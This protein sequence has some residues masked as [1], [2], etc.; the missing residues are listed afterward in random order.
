MYRI[1]IALFLLTPLSV[2][3]Q[4]FINKNKTQALKML[5][6]YSTGAGFE[7]PVI[8]QTDSTIHCSVKDTSGAT[9]NFIFRFD[10]KNKC[11]SEE[12]EASCDS[13]YRKYLIETLNKKIYGWTKINE[14]QYVSKYSHQMILELP[15]DGIGFSYKILRTDWTKKLYELISSK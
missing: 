3:S 2:F 14:N 15:A 10:K 13:C 12:L 4:T 6:K 5:D 7:K 11:K 8:T 1:I 9:T